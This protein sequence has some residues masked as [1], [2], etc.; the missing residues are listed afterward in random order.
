MNTLYS[1]SPVFMGILTL[2][3]I[4]LVAWFVYYLNLAKKPAQNLGSDT[5]KLQHIK[6]IGLF[7]LVI[8]VLHQLLAWYKMIHNIQQAADIN[9]EM[10]LSALKTS[11]VPLIY[12]VIIYLLSLILWLVAGFIFR[13]ND[14]PVD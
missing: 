7:A 2:V 13:N 12:G 8:G 9:T 14:I 6:S 11:M 10:V 1:N 4:T 5:S 3:L